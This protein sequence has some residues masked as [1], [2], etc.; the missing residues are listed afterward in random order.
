MSQEALLNAIKMLR[1]GNASNLFPVLAEALVEINNALRDLE[2]LQA[3]LELLNSIAPTFK[4]R[5][6]N[7]H[8]QKSTLSCA[9]EVDGIKIS[10]ED[11]TTLRDLL[12]T[13]LAE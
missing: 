9:V 5:G 11:I 8:V 13:W 3:E 4:T 1:G 10:R 6:K 12:S 2:A 7:G